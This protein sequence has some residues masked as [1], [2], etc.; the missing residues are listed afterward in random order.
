MQSLDEE[1]VMHFFENSGS[2]D[3][4]IPNLNTVESQDQDN[5]EFQA[6]FTPKMLNTPSA[7]SAVKDGQWETSTIFFS[8]IV[9]LLQF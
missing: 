4:N 8:Q 6:S 3:N 9:R 5:A 2:T 7:R 1:G